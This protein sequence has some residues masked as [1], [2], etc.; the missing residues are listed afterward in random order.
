VVFTGR[1]SDTSKVLQSVWLEEFLIVRMPFHIVAVD[2]IK[3]IGYT[4]LHDRIPAAKSFVAR[5]PTIPKICFRTPLNSF[6]RGYVR[7]Y[8]FLRRKQNCPN[9]ARLSCDSIHRLVPK[10]RLDGGVGEASFNCVKIP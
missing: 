6:A 8:K 5:V 1:H 3:V 9:A 2:E 7:N 10:R 4:A